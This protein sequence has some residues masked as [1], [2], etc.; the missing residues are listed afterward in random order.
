MV[1]ILFLPNAIGAHRR[2]LQFS[3]VRTASEH[4]PAEETNYALSKTLRVTLD[5]LAARA[6]LC[7]I[8]KT[9][10]VTSA[11]MPPRL[12]QFSS[13]WSLLLS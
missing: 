6:A 1:T 2:A 10:P 3:R 11:Q 13:L 7:I 9:A 8:Q 5:W 4:A 12:V